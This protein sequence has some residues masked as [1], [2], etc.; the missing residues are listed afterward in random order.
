MIERIFDTMIKT[1]QDPE[2]DLLFII[3]SNCQD[4]QDVDVMSSILN[5]P[6]IGYSNYF[7][8]DIISNY[9]ASDIIEHTVHDASTNL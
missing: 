3:C 4:T 6:D 5:D 2:F 7:A 8:S 1:F 9:F